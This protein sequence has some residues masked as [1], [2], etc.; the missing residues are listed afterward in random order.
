MKRRMNP[1]LLHF[2]LVG[3]LVGSCSR[4]GSSS[5]DAAVTSSATFGELPELVFLDGNRDEVS[6]AQMRGSVW[7]LSTVSTSLF[8]ANKDFMERLLQVQEILGGTD[9]RI[10][11]LSMDPV[12]DTPEGLSTL[13]GRIGADPHFWSFWVGTEPNTALLLHSAYRSALVGVS[14]IEMDR[15]MSSSFESRVVAIDR[16]GEV[17]GTYDLLSSDG[18]ELLL[19]KLRQLNKE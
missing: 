1:K 7:V 9:T 18:P 4:G 16:Q 14:A 17:R 2:V 13:A 15:F 6:P 11:S 8:S 5:L 10:V 12:G 3:L 19:G